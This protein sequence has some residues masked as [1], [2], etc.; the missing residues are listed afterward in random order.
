MEHTIQYCISKNVPI[1][2]EEA[3]SIEY[4]ETKETKYCKIT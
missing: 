4:K 1:L 2:T 3:S